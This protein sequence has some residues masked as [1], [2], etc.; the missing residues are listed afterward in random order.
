MSKLTV[1]SGKG[2]LKLRKSRKLVGIKTKEEDVEKSDFVSAKFHENLGGFKIVS[3]E[4]GEQDL[5]AQLDEVRQKDEVEVGTHVYLTE[6]SDRPIVPTGEIIIVFQEAASEEEQQLVLDE[7]YLELV[8]RRGANRIIARVSDKSPNPLKVANFLQ[9]IALVKLAEP[10]IDTIVDEYEFRV[11]GDHLLAHQWH[12]RNTGRIVDTNYRTK[13]GADARILDAWARLGNA[14]SSNVTIA[15]VDNG[16]DLTHPDLQSKVVKPYDLWTQSSRLLQGDSRF[17]HG[18]PCA[19]LA[20]ATANGSGMVGVA[21]EAR[22]MPV[23]GTSFSF[24]ATEQ[25]FDY[26]VDNGADIISCSWGTTDSNFMLS[27]MKEE[28][29]TRAAREGRNGKGCVVLFAVGNEDKDFVSFYA[30]HP[31]VIAVSACTSKDLHAEYANRGR[32]VSVCAPSNGDWP[33]IAAR[34]WWD[35]GEKHRGPGNFMFWA[36]GKP[37]G[38]RYKHFGGTSAA[39]PIVAGVCALM[40]SANP[41]LTAR[42]VKEILQATADKVGASWEYRNGHSPKFGYGRVNADKA[43]A[44]AIRRKKSSSP[45]S[46]PT[47]VPAPRPAVS[48]VPGQ[49]T[50]LFRF[51]VKPQIARGWSV[52]I[53]VFADYGNVLKQAQEIEHSL[54]EPVLVNIL[55][56][57]RTSYRILVGAFPERHQANALLSKMKT[58]GMNG[59]VKNLADL[60]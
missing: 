30:A 54:N 42:E 7:F 49:T 32:E 8:D 52:Q 25:M 20:L 57:G 56:S 50:G 5:D 28:V 47:P 2:E 10:D 26:C 23:S 17:H 37:R 40:L 13:P 14:G 55:E 18:T 6:G 48:N 44:E 22:F 45:V 41:D 60:S 9:K 34:A 16:F 43:V 24:R 4:E 51:Q 12:L 58:K 19:S 53:G 1:K 21:P 11:P 31:D 46:D 59:F 38:D 36:D 35:P 15:V 29:I 27:P 39:T 33:L 3:L